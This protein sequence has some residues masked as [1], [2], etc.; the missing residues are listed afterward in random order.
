MPACR[1][2]NSNFH[3]TVAHPLLEFGPNGHDEDKLPVSIATDAHERTW[4]DGLDQEDDE[5][6]ATKKGLICKPSAAEFVYK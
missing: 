2:T 1:L 3:E 6:I 4:V 5:S